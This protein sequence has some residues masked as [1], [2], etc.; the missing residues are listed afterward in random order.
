M[1]HLVI[2]EIGF[3]IW[4]DW[5][6]DFRIRNFRWRWPF[7]LLEVLSP[8]IVRVAEDSITTKVIVGGI[9]LTRKACSIAA[10]IEMQQIR[11]LEQKFIDMIVVHNM[12]TNLPIGWV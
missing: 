7:P 10:R 8:E 5:I 9:C 6:N 1:K 11:Y 2:F 4:Y 3:L 12:K